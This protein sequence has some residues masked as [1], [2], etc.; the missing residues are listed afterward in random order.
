MKMNTE[1]L[2]WAAKENGCA[3]LKDKNCD[4][5]SFF[6]TKYDYLA[7]KDKSILCYWEKGICDS[8]KYQPVKSKCKL[9]YE[10]NQFL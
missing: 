6:K 5:C 1:N 2:C 8:C 4:K 10:I 9:S 3:I 7:D